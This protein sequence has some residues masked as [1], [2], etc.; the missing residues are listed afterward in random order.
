MLDFIRYKKNHIFLLSDQVLSLKSR[1]QLPI[2]MTSR[3]EKAAESRNSP[4]HGESQKYFYITTF[5]CQMNMHDSEAAEGLLLRAGYRMAPKPESADIVLFNTCCVRDHAEQRLYSRLY[6][7][8]ALKERNPHLLVGVGG[9]VAQKEKERLAEKFPHVDIVFG[10]NTIHE[11][12][13]LVQRAEQGERPLISAP[14]DGPALRSM[15]NPS[16]SQR[17]H[18]WVSIMRGCDNYCTYCIVPYVRGPQRSKHPEDIVEEVEDLVQSGIKEI[19]LL[20]Q[21][22]NAFG[23]DLGGDASFASLLRAID[24]IPNLLRIRFTTSHPKDISEEL[25]LAIRDVPSVCEHLHLPVQSGSARILR[26]MNRN[27]TAEEYLAKVEK[28]R[29]YVPEISLTTD[30]IVGFPGETEEDFQATRSLL[31]QVRFDGAYIFKFSPR[32][33]TAAAEMNGRVSRDVIKRRHRELLDF[34]K[35]ISS[36][37]LK[38]LLDSTQLVLPEKADPKREGHLLGRTRGHRTASFAAPQ[39]FVGSEVAVRISRIAGWTLFGQ[40]MDT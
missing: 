36:D 28:L 24:R 22:V 34:Q 18:A 10:T 8:K 21:N 1:R 2:K 14:E 29:Q 40:L 3:K 31:E 15:E 19:T 39:D 23:K 38:Q 16:V 30:V 27:Y 11:I 32:E 5:G 6:Q 7:L 33:G 4:P 25:M 13:S 26:Q 17:L 37:S 12:V 35:D 20:G 9:C